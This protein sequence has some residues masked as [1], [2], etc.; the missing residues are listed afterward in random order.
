M[1]ATETRR[2]RGEQEVGPVDRLARTART[3]REGKIG[4]PAMGQGITETREW[5]GLRLDREGG[6]E[7]IWKA[8][9]S[10]CMLNRDTL[11]A[12]YIHG[13]GVG[14]FCFHHFSSFRHHHHGAR[15]SMSSSS[16]AIPEL[17][18]SVCDIMSVSSAIG[19][20]GMFSFPAPSQPVPRHFRSNE[21]PADMKLRV[22]KQS[23][24]RP[25]DRRTSRSEQPVTLAR[26]KFP[27]GQS[28]TLSILLVDSPSVHRGRSLDS[29]LR[30]QTAASPL[31]L[32][33]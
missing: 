3:A 2:V 26:V 9:D 16:G 11:M 25:L 17:S 15:H 22:A 5:G 12:Q 18:G 32:P 23:Q 8:S 29:S 31:L 13:S 4:A 24:K 1:D 30:F 19:Q 10:G 20:R 6:T 14:G 27:G 21:K 28:A 33:P 7:G